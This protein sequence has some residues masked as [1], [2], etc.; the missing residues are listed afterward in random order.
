MTNRPG[1][2]TSQKWRMLEVFLAGAWIGNLAGI[3]WG[4]ELRTTATLAGIGIA[5]AGLVVALTAGAYERSD[6]KQLAANPEYPAWQTMNGSMDVHRRA[7]I[8]HTLMRIDSAPP[9]EAVA[10]DP[11]IY[12]DVLREISRCRYINHRDAPLQKDKLYDV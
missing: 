4:G 11:D 10:I 3:I 2:V 1:L 5:I 12:D 6:A 8:N 9:G 7:R